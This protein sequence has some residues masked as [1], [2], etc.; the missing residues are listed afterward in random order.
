NLSGRDRFLFNHVLGLR[1]ETTPAQLK[2]VLASLRKILADHPRV[3]PEEARARFLRLGP[4]SLDVELRAYVLAADFA[5]FLEVQ[6][7]LL[8]LVLDAVA[9]AG[10]GIAFPSQTLYLGKDTPPGASP[11]ADAP[12]N[13]P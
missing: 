12:S 11:D 8:F 5:G 6:E 9:A 4:S 3:T 2:T 1:Y 10:A 13:A 7:E